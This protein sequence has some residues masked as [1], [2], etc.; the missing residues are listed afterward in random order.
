MNEKLF[1][2]SQEI[3]KYDMNGNRIYYRNIDFDIE[4]DNPNIIKETKTIIRYE[5]S[6]DEDR[7]LICIKASGKG[8]SQTTAFRYDHK[9]NV[10]FRNI[11]TNSRLIDENHYFYDENNRCIKEINNTDTILYRYDKN[12]NMISRGDFENEVSVL[13]EYDE[14]NNM[15]H[16]VNYDVMYEEWHRYDNKGNKIYTLNIYGN[17][18]TYEYDENNNMIYKLQ[19][20]NFDEYHTYNH[21]NKKG[22]LI[23]SEVYYPIE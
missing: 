19:K 10:V 3:F 1:M 22:K 12:G 16:M 20:F 21:Y 2:T 9:N 13:F 15:I 18:V 14:N 11:I 23:K 7:N 6:Y 17:E 5:N 4:D 8:Y